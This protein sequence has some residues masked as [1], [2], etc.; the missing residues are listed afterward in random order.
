MY[1][2][3]TL[4]MIPMQTKRNPTSKLKMKNNNPKPCEK[5]LASKHK[6]IAKHKTSCVENFKLSKVI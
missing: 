1:P 2:L 5:K 4:N 6:T 3:Q